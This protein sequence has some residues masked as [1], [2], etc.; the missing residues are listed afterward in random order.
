MKGEHEGERSACPLVRTSI[1]L[2]RSREDSNP[3]ALDLLGFV[4]RDE[5][6]SVAEDEIGAI[7]GHPSSREV[8]Q[9][10]AATAQLALGRVDHTAV[11]HRHDITA[12]HQLADVEQARVHSCPQHLFGLPAGRA[13]FDGPGRRPMLILGSSV[14]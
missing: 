1:R 4:G 3:V 5:Q 7:D 10:S 2:A 14:R 8:G 11:G 13:A 9:P 12:G 6:E